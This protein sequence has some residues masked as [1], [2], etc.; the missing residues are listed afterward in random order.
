MYV[1]VLSIFEKDF[2]EVNIIR[3]KIIFGMCQLNNR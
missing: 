1:Y 2:K 3:S